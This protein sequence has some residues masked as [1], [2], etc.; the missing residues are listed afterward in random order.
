MKTKGKIF[1]I[2]IFLIFAFTMITSHSLVFAVEGEKSETT[3]KKSEDKQQE[4]Q[5]STENKKE[6]SDSKN[7]E[8]NQKENANQNTANSDVTNKPNEEQQQVNPDNSVSGPDQTPDSAKPESVTNMPNDVGNDV[9]N[10]VEKGISK[11]IINANN[12]GHKDKNNNDDKRK[13]KSDLTVIVKLKYPKL[14]YSKP[15]YFKKVRITIGDKH[16]KYYDLSDK[17]DSIKV[18]HLDIGIGKKFE[19]HLNNPRTDDGEQASGINH[20]DKRPE[21]ISI[22]VP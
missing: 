3:D 17:P 2:T 19:V 12:D 11:D 7:L 22:R 14:A 20:K 1:A 10:G 18:K 8:D 15:Y 4:Q 6:V 9:V 5:Q 21:I 13:H 16:N